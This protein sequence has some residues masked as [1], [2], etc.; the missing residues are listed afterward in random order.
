MGLKPNIEVKARE[1]SLIFNIVS[2][3]NSIL[4][5]KNGRTIEALQ[6]ITNQ[7]VYNELNLY[8][9]FVIDVSDYR[10]NRDKRIEKMAKMTAKEVAKSKCPIKLDPMN[11]YDRR[12]VHNA[13]T[14][15]NDVTTF[16]E[17][18]EPYR[19]IVIRPKED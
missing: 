19:C 11:S 14:N 7:V 17:G 5:G 13:L 8:Y 18:E 2:D 6:S 3:N 16:S 10:Q 12:I 9:R 4:I 1:E 15:S